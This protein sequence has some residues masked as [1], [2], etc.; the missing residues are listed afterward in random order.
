MTDAQRSAALLRWYVEMGAD[1]AIGEIPVDRTRPPPPRP[2]PPPVAARPGAAPERRASP[3]LPV[4]AAAP[5]P[6]VASAAAL[7]EAAT[8][9][10]ELERAVAAFEGGAL[11]QRATNTV[12][13][14][15]NPP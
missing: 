14:D 1:E 8:S 13:A 6:L 10:A 7:A 11:R 2:A 12:V 4:R 9:P 5:G 15:A 3:P